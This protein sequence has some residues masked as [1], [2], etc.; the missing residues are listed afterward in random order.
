MELEEMQPLWE[1][2]N[3][4]LEDREILNKQLIMNMTQERY[5]NRLEGISRWERNG[6][7]I[8]FSMAIF[9]LFNFTK[10][11]TPFLWISGLA[12]LLIL[13][14]LPSLTLFTLWRLQNI[15]FHHKSYKD[16]ILEFKRRKNQVLQAQKLGLLLGLVLLFT[17]LP[18][19]GKLMNGKDLFQD[20][21]VWLWYVPMGS[22][23]FFFFAKWGYGCYK[24][25]TTSAEEILSEVEEGVH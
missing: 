5:S 13:I 1:K 23:F 9:I 22:L 25:I 19:A 7:I 21:S 17:G 16:T 3:H 10:L 11:D 24:S 2:M 12:S 15:S 4:Q 6:A 18:V 20:T 8:C 14:G